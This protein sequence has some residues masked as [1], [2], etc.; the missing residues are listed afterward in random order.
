MEKILLSIVILAAITYLF[1][2]IFL[3]LRK[4]SSRC[5]DDCGCSN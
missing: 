2:K 4:K 3:R 1:S 5:S